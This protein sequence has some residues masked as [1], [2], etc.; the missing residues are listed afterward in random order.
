MEARVVGHETFQKLHGLGLRNA[1]L[2][3]PKTFMDDK[4]YLR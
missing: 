1:Q 4:S 2:A 3:L